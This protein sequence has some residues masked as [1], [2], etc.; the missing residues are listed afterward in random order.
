MSKFKYN[1]WHDRLSIPA[2]VMLVIL[3]MLLTGCAGLSGKKSAESETPEM[4]ARKAMTAFKEGDYSKANKIFEELRDKYPFSQYSLLADLKTADCRYYMGDYAEAL[5]LYDEFEASHPTNEAIPYVLFQIGMCSYKQIGTVDRDTG[6]AER[7]I[8][9]FTRLLR[10]YPKSPYTLEAEARIKAAKNFL[11][12]HEMYV[13]VFYV[14][15]EEFKQAEGRL[16]YLLVNY[17]D[18][19]ECVQAKGLLA[20]IRSGKPPRRTWRDWIPELSLPDW[21]TFAAGGMSMQGGN[22]TS[23]GD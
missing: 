8:K 1:S 19:E 12:R 18:S 3:I 6:D 7:A 10:V 17:P 21:R 15:T 14:R 22:D 2:A 16:E 9:A 5:D 20:A 11:A 4:V 23:G 13:A